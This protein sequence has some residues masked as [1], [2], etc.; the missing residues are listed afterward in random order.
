MDEAKIINE[1][2]VKEDKEY[3]LGEVITGVAPAI[4]CNGKAITE[5]ELLIEIA[6]DIKKLKKNLI[7]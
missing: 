2:E 1:K 4:V 5:L 7:G 3:T 6:N